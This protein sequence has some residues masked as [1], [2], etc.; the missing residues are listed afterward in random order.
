MPPVPKAISPA[1]FGV[2][3]VCFLLPWVNLTCAGQTYAT[4][5]GFDLVTGTTVKA[6]DG[7]D[8]ETDTGG[9]AVLIMVSALAGVFV[10]F[11]KYKD[12]EHIVL[13]SG[14]LGLTALGEVIWMKLRI[15]NDLAN[16]TQGMVTAEFTTGFWIA[17][18]GFLATIILNGYAYLQLKK[19]TSQT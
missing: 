1:L 8:R 3:L 11:L 10:G 9:L 17:L 13:G 2:I 14:I 6:Q 12:R 19:R 4:L 15:E 16:K 5:T 18:L 7:Q